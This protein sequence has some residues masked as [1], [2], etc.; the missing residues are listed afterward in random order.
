WA[1]RR[2]LPVV[3]P[4]IAISGAAALA[5]LTT[6]GRAARAFA[7]GTVLVVLYLEGRTIMPARARAYYRGSFAAVAALAERLPEDA[8]VGFE[9]ELADEQLQ[10]P[11]WLMTGRETLVL[12]EG[13]TRWRDVMQ[14]L[15]ATGRPVFW[16]GERL[17]SRGDMSGVPM[18]VLP[19]D[20]DV[21]VFVP[22][23]PADI[24][25]SIGVS[26]VLP[27]RVYGVGAGVG[28]QPK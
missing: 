28:A 23:S 21:V 15:V 10:V 19:P 9:G 16:I 12:G 27:L 24:P 2:F 6:R 26:R 20:V 8:I 1:I 18:E 14:A 5:W 3:I 7:A 11:L 25:P 4:G 17:G 13:G 22:D